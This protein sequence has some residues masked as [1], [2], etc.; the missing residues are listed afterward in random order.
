MYHEYQLKVLTRWEFERTNR[1]FH[2][3]IDNLEILWSITYQQGS[4]I[5]DGELH[6]IPNF[7]YLEDLMEQTKMY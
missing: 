6:L 1:G 4:Y 7:G 2:K 3:K 5:I